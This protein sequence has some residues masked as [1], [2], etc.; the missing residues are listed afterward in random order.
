[1]DGAPG[2]GRTCDPRLRRPMLYPL[3]YGRS[4][5]GTSDV[6]HYRAYGC[7]V[8]SLNPHLSRLISLGF[9]S[10]TPCPTSRYH[11]TSEV[12]VFFDT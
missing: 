9:R 11:N 1:M 10:G 3:S 8:S 7:V 4:A 6:L 12:P 5:L 2:R